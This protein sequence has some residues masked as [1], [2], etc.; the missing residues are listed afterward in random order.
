MK[1]LLLF[2][3]IVLLSASGF[4]QPYR[5]YFGNEYTKWSVL[6]EICDA[7]YTTE[8]ASRPDATIVID[9]VTYNKLAIIEMW[10]DTW[11]INVNDSYFDRYF[12]ASNHYLR[13]DQTTGRLY[14][15]TSSDTEEFIVSDMSLKVGDSIRLC[16][17][18]LDEIWFIVYNDDIPYAVVD[19]VY[20]AD[21]LKHIHTSA[22][23]EAVG[24]GYPNLE[25]IEGLGSNLTPTL[26]YYCYTESVEWGMYNNT[27]CYENETYWQH[28]LLDDFDTCY[29]E[30]TGINDIKQAEIKVYPSP[31]EKYIYVDSDSWNKSEIIITNI[32]GQV[33]KDISF[34]GTR[35]SI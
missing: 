18:R 13:E 20:Y 23:F 17:D 10:P 24:G 9:D 32:L 2:L 16:D 22:K 14:L 31:A 26:N 7:V 34:E 27:L 6:S 25:F 1:K 29:V 8:C 21:G 12:L 30:L 19:S 15:R 5:S 28:Y 4:A 33:V 35:T 3:A 11:S